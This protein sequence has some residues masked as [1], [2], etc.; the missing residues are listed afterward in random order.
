MYDVNLSFEARDAAARLPADALKALAEL[1]D[2]LTVSPSVG[3]AYGSPDS[4]L[5]TTAVAHGELLV[6]WLILEPQRR[7]ELLR[8]L[9]LGP[10]HD[11]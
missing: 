8:L 3:R 10:V 1:I 5:R 11:R 7:V 2:V 9:W 4:D 6:V